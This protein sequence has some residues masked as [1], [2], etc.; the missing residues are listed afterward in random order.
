M[1]DQYQCQGKRKGE[2]KHGEIVK[3]WL[4]ENVFGQCYIL[5]PTPDYGDPDFGN[6]MQY[7]YEYEVY[8]DSVRAASVAPDY[9]I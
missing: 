3:G 1:K 6:V 7:F 5:V 4:I 8:P 2:K 9:Q